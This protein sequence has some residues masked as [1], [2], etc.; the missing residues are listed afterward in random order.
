MTHKILVLAEAITCFARGYLALVVMH[1][2]PAHLIAGD[3]DLLKRLAG[4]RHPEA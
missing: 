4:R 2:A 1:M 3:E